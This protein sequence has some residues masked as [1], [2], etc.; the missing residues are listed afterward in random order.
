M[1]KERLDNY[2]KIEE[3]RGSKILIY[4]TSDR[5]NA[6]TNIG[7][8]IFAP[9]VNHLDQ[10]GDVEKISLFIYS[11]GGSTLAAWSLVNLIRSF[12]KDFEVIHSWMDI[13][14]QINTSRSMRILSERIL[15]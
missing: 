7:S 15:K 2:K 4:V 12:C 3:L 13:F 10:L 5:Q 9:F 8:D 14:S 1:R 11:N 6:E